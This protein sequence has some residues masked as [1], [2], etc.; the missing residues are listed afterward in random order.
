MTLSNTNFLYQGFY[1]LGIAASHTNPDHVL[2]G[3]LNLWKTE[4][5]TA[6]FTPLGGYQGSI[7]YIHPDQQEIEI[8][9]N[10]MWVAN[11]GGINYSTDL[12]STHESRKK[13]I[14]GSDF[15]GFGSGWN[16]DI[17]VGGRYH[18]GNTAFKS[19]Y[20]E[21]AYRRLGGAEAATG[22]VNPGIERKAYFSDIS[23][24]IIPNTISGEIISLPSLNI[25]PN[26]TFYAAHS[27]ELEF[28]PRYYKTI[29]VG[30]ENKLWK[31]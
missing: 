13:G 28:D 21:G 23:S 15:W 22:Y 3:G 12:F 2:I 29:Y 8:N 17:L 26:E 19:G 4:D 25:Y 31:S 18:N 11:D 7:S 27:S 1:N 20:P 5:G 16:E 24:K 6:S 30:R 14:I 10:D 9:G